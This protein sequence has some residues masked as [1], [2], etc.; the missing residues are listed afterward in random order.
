YVLNMEKQPQEH[1]DGQPEHGQK[2]SHHDGIL[3]QAHALVIFR[4]LT[5]EKG[6]NGEAAQGE[7]APDYNCSEDALRPVGSDAED[8][9]QVA[10]HLVNEAVVIPGLPRPEP[11]P[12]RAATEG[13]DENHGD[14]WDD[15]A[16]KKSADGKLT[17]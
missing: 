4:V 14:Q 9:G 17:F 12:A 3:Q 11:L 1:L 13:S 15:E 16:E 8:V 5:P 2:K 10:V 7:K 6:V